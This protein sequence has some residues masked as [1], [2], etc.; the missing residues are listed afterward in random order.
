MKIKKI[1]M[2]IKIL[3][4]ILVISN[5]IQNKI[6]CRYLNK[7]QIQ[8]QQANVCNQNECTFGTCEILSTYN[9]IVIKV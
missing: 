8:Q 2:F 7:R 1:K 9:V 5:N 6:E 4:T 3:L